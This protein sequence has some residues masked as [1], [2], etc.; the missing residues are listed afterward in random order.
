MNIICFNKKAKKTLRRFF[1]EV[2]MHFLCQI[3]SICVRHSNSANEASMLLPKRYF[4]QFYLTLETPKKQ[5]GQTHSN[6]LFE[7][8][9]PFYGI[10]A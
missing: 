9:W 5:N 3:K 7:C 8:V 2:S 10:G 4:K 6:G 1:D